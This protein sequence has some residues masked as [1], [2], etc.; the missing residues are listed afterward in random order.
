MTR[1][2]QAGVLSGY[3]L[4]VGLPLSVYWPIGSSV[5]PDVLDLYARPEL[6]LADLVVGLLLLA[7]LIGRAGRAG[8]RVNFRL[9]APL[10]APVVLALLTAP[11][12]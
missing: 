2:K 6:Y 10:L 4:A 12:A 1:L 8:Q 9:T 5:A 11:L 7:H 3:A